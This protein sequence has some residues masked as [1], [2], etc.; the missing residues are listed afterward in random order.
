MSNVTQILDDLGRGDANAAEQLLPAVYG[1]LR[2]LAAW[3]LA[4][5]KPGQTLEATALV[6]DA[7]LRLVDVDRRRPIFRSQNRTRNPVAL[8]WSRDGT[9]LASL[10]EGLIEVVLGDIGVSR[11]E[12]TG[13]AVAAAPQGNSF[14]VVERLPSGRSR[15][16]IVGT[17]RELFSGAGTFDG[18]AWSPNGRWLLVTWR[19]ADQ[20]VFVRTG[21]T[22]RIDAVANVSAQFEGS[23]PRIEGWCCGR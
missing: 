21:A 22:P 14:A 11:L 5:E 10:G 2:K 4:K 12:G 9:S 6:H 16:S 8:A 1:E 7:Y 15:V 19:D 20:W 17:G 23:F 3:R 18:L 13:V